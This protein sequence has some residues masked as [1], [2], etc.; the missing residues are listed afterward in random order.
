MHSERPFCSDSLL[1]LRQPTWPAISRISAASL[2]KKIA[3]LTMDSP[4]AQTWKLLKFAGLASPLL[5][6]I[7]AHLSQQRA[8]RN[9]ER[10]PSSLSHFPGCAVLP[11]GPR[12]GGY[13]TAPRSPPLGRR[14]VF[15]PKKEQV[16]G[17]NGTTPPSPLHWPRISDCWSV[18]MEKSLR[19]GVMEDRGDWVHDSS[20]DHRGRPP[21]RGAT[22]SWKA[23]M[24]IICE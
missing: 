9:S 21:S 15:R 1:L 20:V 13:I 5:D 23:A 7:R 6:S 4:F 14:L 16:A 18:G 22:G 24:F 12:G 2:L 11:C 10:G 19:V 3:R 17:S 8:C